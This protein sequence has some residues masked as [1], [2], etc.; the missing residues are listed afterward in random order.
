MHATPHPGSPVRRGDRGP[1]LPVVDHYCGVEARMRKSLGPAGGARPRVRR[2]ARLR[3]R[4]PVGGEAEHAALVVS[5]V[6]SADNHFGRVGARAHP[7]DHPCFEADVDTLV[8]QAGERLAYLMIPKVRDAS[9][10]ERAAEAVAA[11]QA[12]HGQQ[13]PRCRC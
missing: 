10:L 1:Q 11:C 5:L 3:R 9:D 4:R 12:R 6:N 13:R 8:G 2:H 7:F